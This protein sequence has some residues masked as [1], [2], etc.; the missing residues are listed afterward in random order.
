MIFLLLLMA[1]MWLWRPDARSSMLVMSEEVSSEEPVEE[2]KQSIEMTTNND[3]EL[4]LRR[5]PHS[6]SISD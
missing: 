2:E 1:V 4:Y 6:F 5:G 3:R